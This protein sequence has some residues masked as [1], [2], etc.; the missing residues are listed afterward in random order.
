M[1][2][3]LFFLFVFTFNALVNAQNWQVTGVVTSTEDK[4][5]MIG[6][7]VVVKGVTGV[8]TV[9][10]IDGKFSIK[11]P[12]GKSIVF[13][14][15]GYLAQTKT[16]NGNA[17]LNVVLQPDSKMLDEVVA[18]G[19]GT[20]KK[21]VVTG[22]IGRV[23]AE[24]LE[25]LSPTRIDNVLKGQTSGVTITQASG[26]P[27]DG[28]V[29]RIRG[30]G[31]INNS[32]PLYIVDGMP[33]DGGID[34]LNPSDIKSVE[35]LKDAA[36]GA[37]YGS[38]A[39][40]GVILVTTKS[41]QKGSLSLK[42]DFSYGWQNPWKKRSVLN[43]SEYV[44]LMNEAQVNSGS[45][46]TYKTNGTDTD[47][48]D[49]V[50][51]YNAPVVN[52]Q[53]SL[54]GGNDKS[55][56]FLS[57][58]FFKQDGIVGGNFDRSNYDRTNVR[59]NNT[60]NLFDAT[61]Q[62]SFLNLA[63]LTTSL[64][65]SRVKS[66]GIGT[67]SEYGTPLGS[68]LL[69]SPLLPV[70]A[71][72]PAATLAVQKYAIKDKNGNVYTLPGDQYNEIINPVAALQLPGDVNY[73]DKFVSTFSLEMQVYN[74]LTFKSSFGTDLS[75]YGA[76]GWTPNYYLGKTT[77]NTGLTKAY[78]NKHNDVVWQ[79]EN[80]LTYKKKF[81]KNDITVLLGQSAKRND[82]SAIWAGDQDLI[83]PTNPNLTNLANTTHLPN[84]MTASGSYWYSTLASYFGRI[85][86]NYDEKYML[87]ITVRDDA[88]SNFGPNNHWALFPAISGGWVLTQE[89]F[90][91]QRPEWL[92]FL[93]LRGSWGKNGNQEIGQF[94][95]TSLMSTNS[96]YIFGSG[97]SEA[98]TTGSKP[99]LLSNASLK[100]EESEQTDFGVD[101]KFFN[102]SLNITVDW[103]DKKTNGML[104]AMPIPQY[105][106]ND[107][108]WGNV[109]SMDNQGIEIDVNYKF[110]VSDVK[111]SVSGNASYIKNELIK[112]G[113]STG[114]ATY[115]AV[116]NIGTITRGANG[117]PFPYFYG[118][119]TNGIF[120]TQDEVNSYT[121]SKGG[122]IQP[123]AK[124]GDVK[125]VDLNGDGAITD[126]DRTKIGK[127][128]PDWTYGF[129][130]SLEWKGFDFSA[131][132]N[133]SVGN[134]VYDATRRIDLTSVNLPSY[135]LDRWTGPNTSNSIP[136]MSITDPNNNW[137]SSDL[138]VQDGSYLRLRNLQIGYSLPSKIV[139][140]VFLSNA[141]FYVSAENLLTITSY[142]GF[143]PEISSGGTSLGVDR[144]VYPQA[145]T[146]S[147]G[148]SIT[149]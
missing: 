14:Y 135:M 84:N 116:Q 133:G 90:M 58:G 5:P 45:L 121:N 48:Q 47:W 66:K 128:M 127:G 1:K 27:G 50:F 87:E 88:S 149:F 118:L 57:L 41:G 81:N 129:T 148:A 76:D 68:A 77:N 19:Y 12:E 102:S 130:L 54:M 20:Q 30:I 53:V 124:P 2:K 13:S 46:L 28:S 75:F 21:S 106:G 131:F 7:S 71:T 98:I 49:E 44:M 145:R 95:Y 70:Y 29:V 59:F 92:D 122:L 32:D 63:K 99:L 23:T 96:N 80:T 67:N 123:N 61:K 94:K 86:Y 51:N 25:K 18:V 143:D 144:G 40:N 111:V 93:K 125:F 147:V 39:A 10:D 132:F 42:Y 55:T 83:D 100:W 97:S 115:D 56:Y 142:R 109:G 136:R 120:Q 9:T 85:S 62:R 140:T 114:W 52:H 108:P 82:G 113:N 37:V 15:I 43:A 117:E 31:S 72:D 134:D 107:A 73:S 4:L 105:I 3:T 8:G 104:M 126:A 65:Y 146:I 6:V 137:I 141:R 17:T 38:R 33:I 91:N 74:N 35:V 69:L 24:N 138:Y 22:S 64:A 89:Q 79:L 26:Q 101:A 16:V 36:S 139:K 34:Y 103:F 60:Y 110:K 119:K 112:L 11:V 78:S